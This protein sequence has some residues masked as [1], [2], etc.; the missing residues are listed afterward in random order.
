MS[1]K[2]MA[3]PEEGG[4]EGDDITMAESMTPTGS[5]MKSPTR[6]GTGTGAKTGFEP[7]NGTTV[8]AP[9]V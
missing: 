2:E 5:A 7:D 8:A 6:T 4:V 3:D 1:N 9:C